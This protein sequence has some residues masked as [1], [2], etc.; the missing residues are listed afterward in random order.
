MPSRIQAGADCIP[1]DIVRFSAA[2][3]G[4][5]RRA[6]VPRR[7]ARVRPFPALHCCAAP[8]AASRPSHFEN[9][10]RLTRPLSPRPREQHV[11]ECPGSDE[12]AWQ[13]GQPFRSRQPPGV[14]T[15]ARA[16]R[17]RARVPTRARLPPIEVLSPDRETV[18]FTGPSRK[19]LNSRNAIT[20]LPCIH[21]CGIPRRP[22]GD[23]RRPGT[24]PP[25]GR[26]Y[27]VVSRM[28][29]AERLNLPSCS[30][31]LT[32]S[33]IR[34]SWPNTGRL[35]A[36]CSLN[37]PHQVIAYDEAARPLE[38]IDSTRRVVAIRFESDESF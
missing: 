21:L 1:D 19:V 13:R 37:K 38:G 3:T 34:R 9:G 6:A 24:F 27:A 30:S 35:L 22:V 25:A 12:R 16:P 4:T 15:D 28:T 23:A 2:D 5:P 29:R 31:P 18:Q 10:I 17:R 32:A 11:G 36:R 7:P 33:R 20:G 14:F 26:T 8:V